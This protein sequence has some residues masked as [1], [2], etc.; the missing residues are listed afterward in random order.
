VSEE[1]I[2][3]SG[4]PGPTYLE[5][6]AKKAKTPGSETTKPASAP[7]ADSTD[8]NKKESADESIP[9]SL[10]EAQAELKRLRKEAADAQKEIGRKGKDQGDLRGTVAQLQ[11]ELDLIKRGQVQPEKKKDR[12]S[13]QEVVAA[14]P[15]IAGLKDENKKQF[16]DLFD[17]VNKHIREENEEENQ[18]LKQ[19]L[20]QQSE[21]AAK[22]RLRQQ[23][24]EAKDEVG[25]EL[26]Q[27]AATD[28]NAFLQQNQYAYSV[29]E[30]LRFVR[31]EEYA[32]AVA[33]RREEED[34]EEIATKGGLKKGRK[35]TEFPK[36][37]P[38]A[39]D[40]TKYFMDVLKEESK[41]YG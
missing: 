3:S 11:A 36:S 23:V 27:E 1:D 7:A 9:D 19:A 40:K 35:A 30:A 12:K 39:S 2:L 8:A 34:K 37:D 32:A 4:T 33:A 16:V 26:L 22:E 41:K 13:L 17:Q 25:T 10:E 28:V 38:V 6:A 14:H 31:P 21:E 15:A 29:K 18:R 5:I 20:G 24:K